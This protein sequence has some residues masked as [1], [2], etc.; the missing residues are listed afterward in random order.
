MYTCQL[1]TIR[2]MTGKRLQ[3]RLQ[4]RLGWFGSMFWFDPH[5]QTC[6]GANTVYSSDGHVL[7]K[8]RK[9]LSRGQNI[10]FLRNFGFG[11]GTISSECG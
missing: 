11:A 5:R 1:H 9:A 8:N 6:T 4:M 10:G 7:A 3:Q 2:R